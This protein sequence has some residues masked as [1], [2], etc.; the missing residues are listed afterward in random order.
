MLSNATIAI[1]LTII[2]LSACCLDSAGIYGYIAG[3][4]CILGGL[5]AGTGCAIKALGER[6]KEERRDR[7][8]SSRR[9]DRLD[10]DVEF[11]ELEEVRGCQRWKF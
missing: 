9:V 7:F 5:I 2:A 1:G 3:A 10:G 8:Y 6:R 4:V 11:I